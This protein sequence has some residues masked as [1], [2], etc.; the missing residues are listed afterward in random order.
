MQHRV[1][2]SYGTA[3]ATLTTLDGSKYI[4]NNTS[5]KKA[6]CFF[7]LGIPFH[8]G[9]PGGGPRGPGEGPNVRWRLGPAGRYILMLTSSAAVPS[10]H[11]HSNRT[12]PY[13]G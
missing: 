8:G 2:E 1:Y 13:G 3:G 12:Q 9:A 11:S 5:C 7:V 6:T 4:Y 10:F